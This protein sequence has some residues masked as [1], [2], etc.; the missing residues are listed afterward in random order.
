MGKS[1]LS[2]L[3]FILHIPPFFLSSASDAVLEAT[4][5]A[6]P[7]VGE[8]SMTGATVLVPHPSQQYQ[9]FE[10]T[11]PFLAP[12][13]S[14]RGKTD[15]KWPNCAWQVAT[16]PSASSFGLLDLNAY[17]HTLV[18]WD[19]YESDTYRIK[20]RYPGM[21]YFSI[22][23]Y[24][25]TNGK[26]IA[27]VLD[28]DIHPA[29]GTNP[30][31]DRNA[32]PADR[33]TF[34]VYLTARGDQGWPNELRVKR[35]SDQ[36]Y[37]KE[38]VTIIYRM[39]D[40]DDAIAQV[41]DRNWTSK[42]QFWGFT[43]PAVVEYMTHDGRW[44]EVPACTD[45]GSALFQATFTDLYPVFKHFPATPASCPMA[46]LSDDL[47]PS[48][49][50]FGAGLEEGYAESITSYTNYDT[51]YLYWCA[52]EGKVGPNLVIRMQAKL[53][54]VPQ[55]LYVSD[56]SPS[57]AQMDAYDARYISISTVDML[58]PSPTYQEVKD[59]DIERFYSQVLGWSKNDRTY[60]IVFSRDPSVAKSCELYDPDSQLWLGWNDAYHYGLAPT[61]M[62]S[63]VYRELL[64][65]PAAGN[66]SLVE[67]ERACR[68]A[69][70]GMCGD[71]E[72]L[73]SRMGE[74]YPRVDVF[75]C[76]PSTGIATRLA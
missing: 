21:R 9:H 64:P 51:R 54:R 23:S 16:E 38:P 65:T 20:G 13:P 7:P 50:L 34:E 43:D 59:R 69:G 75:D 4:N 44:T 18:I 53:P 68:G 72:F 52:L 14:D 15:V 46:Q 40:A 2:Y 29:T 49:I 22:Q 57:V 3:A 10:E 28:R 60:S 70:E 45:F 48:V 37:K 30:F 33:G 8:P 12:M 25:F 74:T 76:D 32:T 56:K 67:V 61:R 47:F 35:G 58:Y 42:Q 41:A 66:R 1:T 63:I 17:Y 26:P 31:A 39:Y 5:F 11:Y 19:F 55:G 6:I 27:S 73:R 36:N 71:G 24:E 62:P